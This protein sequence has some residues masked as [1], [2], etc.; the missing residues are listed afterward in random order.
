[1]TATAYAVAILSYAYKA[2]KGFDVDNAIDPLSVEND[3][4]LHMALAAR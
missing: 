2:L 1:M 3:P 4:T